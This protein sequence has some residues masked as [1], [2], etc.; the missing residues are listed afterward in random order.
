MNKNKRTFKILLD[1]NQLGSYTGRIYDASYYIDLRNIL[2]NDEDYDKKYHV[3]CSLRSKADAIVNNT[4]SNNDL[5][6]LNIDFNKGLSTYQYTSPYK[7]ISFILPV[8]VSNEL[9]ATPQTFF[10][11]NERDNMPILLN[12][13]RS[14][15]NI[16]QI[17]PTY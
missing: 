11:L 9:S 3:Y 4:I 13:I 1:S 15:N 14:I 12:N 16:R 8:S 5:Y 2:V 17:F 6:L 7:N 10:N